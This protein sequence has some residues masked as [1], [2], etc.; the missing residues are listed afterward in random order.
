MLQDSM[1]SEGQRGNFATQHIARSWRQAFL[2]F[3]KCDFC[4]PFS[5]EKKS[6]QGVKVI[7]SGACHTAIGIFEANLDLAYPKCTEANTWRDGSN[8][9][10]TNKQCKSERPN[11]T[12]N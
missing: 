2:A 9:R 3:Q 10:S 1:K 6:S 4:C 11:L 5:H 8:I 7:N 12:K